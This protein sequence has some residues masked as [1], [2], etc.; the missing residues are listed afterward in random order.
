MLLFTIKD[1]KDVVLITQHSKFNKMQSHDPKP[2]IFQ[3]AHNVKKVAQK[4]ALND[5][6]SCKAKTGKILTK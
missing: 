6:P 2:N 3:N 4:F 1:F 5:L